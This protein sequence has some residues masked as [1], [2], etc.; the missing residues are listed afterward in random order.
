MSRLE[1]ELRKTLQ[2]RPAPEGF[3]RRLMERIGRQSRA[4]P[5]WRRLLQPVPGGMRWAAATAA[6]A[7]LI[8]AGTGEYRRHQARIAKA[9][10][11]EALY[12]AGAKLT[13]A[14]QMLNEFNR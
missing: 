2:R 10:A 11:M 8:T 7:V 12:I 3:E 6:V 4:L 9:Q 1:D 5:W 13:Q 14:G